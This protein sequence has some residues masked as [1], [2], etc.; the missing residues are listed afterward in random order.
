MLS[1]SDIGVKE[2]TS[3]WGANHMMVA[4]IKLSQTHSFNDED[5]KAIIKENLVDAI[6]HRIYGDVIRTVKRALL[7]L[8][9]EPGS[10][11]SRTLL[12][13]LLDKLK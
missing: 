2:G 7:E 11:L 4:G 3:Q 8:P 6:W 12:E 1:R 10:H 13:E 9:P 5:Q